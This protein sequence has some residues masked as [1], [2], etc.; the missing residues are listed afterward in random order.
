MA[1][2]QIGLKSVLSFYICEKMARFS[3]IST[4]TS[5]RLITVVLTKYICFLPAALRNTFVA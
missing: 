2:H 4:L 3:N 1:I 5:V